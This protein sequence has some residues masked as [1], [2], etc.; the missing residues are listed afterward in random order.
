MVQQCNNTIQPRARNRTQAP[1][2]ATGR[3]NT[4]ISCSKILSTDFGS[5]SKPV[6]VDPATRRRGK[7]ALT[8]ECI[9][10]CI[11]WLVMIYNLATS[12]STPRQSNILI[13]IHNTS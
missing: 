3:Q 2:K 1:I 12:L 4:A 10:A 13:R 8:D 6:Q 7:I 9:E 11:S 5:A